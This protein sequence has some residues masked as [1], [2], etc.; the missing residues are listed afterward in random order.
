ML[1]VPVACTHEG[2]ERQDMAGIN[3][4][5]FGQWRVQ[6]RKQRPYTSKT[7]DLKSDAECWALETE[8][9]WTAVRATVV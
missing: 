3:K 1:G 8:R 6:I 4:L 9:K 2:R 5:A 7:F